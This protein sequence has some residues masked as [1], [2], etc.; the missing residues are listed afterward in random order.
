MQSQSLINWYPDLLEILAVDLVLAIILIAAYRKIFGLI[1][2]VSST[3]EL[4]ERD[5]VA[6]GLVFAGGVLALAIVMTGAVSGEAGK[7]LFREIILV[8]SYGLVGIVMM[9]LS[10]K[11]FDIVT[12]PEIRVQDLIL[13][14]NMAVAIADVGNLLATA[15]II[16]AVMVWVQG[17]AFTG[18][19]AVIT[20]F[21]V[22]QA[23][24][25]L[26]TKYRS[27]VYAHRH[28]GLRLQAALEGG[29]KAL[30]MRYAGHKVGV[31]LAVT[32]ASGF[33]PYNSEKLLL[34][35]LLWGVASIILSIVLSLLAIFARQII[36][37][38]INVVEEVDEQQNLGIGFV[39][40]MIYVSVGLILSSLIA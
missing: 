33:I 15:I 24:I 22:S 36:L 30:A 14:G 38:K 27:K 34:A 4:S 23:V 10:R 11:V 13:K 5:N 2:N 35:C 8:L 26:V 18:L 12:L 9:I 37:A 17:T 7:S 32:A 29:N 25:V 31:A 3:E 40:A 16:R 1:S 6:Y 19:I 39:E 28:Q 21:I 20:G